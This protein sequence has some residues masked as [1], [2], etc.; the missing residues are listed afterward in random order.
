[1]DHLRAEDSQLPSPAVRRPDAA[2]AQNDILKLQQS[3]GN[4]AVAARAQEEAEGSPGHRPNLALG[5]SGP[6][7]L[8]LQR[9]LRELGLGCPADGTFGQSTHDAVVGYQQHHPELLPATGGVGPGTWATVDRET[10]PLTGPT[11]DLLPPNTTN[12]LGVSTSTDPLTQLEIQVLQGTLDGRVPWYVVLPVRKIL[13]V[14]YTMGTAPLLLAK[15]V[16]DV[17]HFV[18]SGRWEAEKAQGH[19]PLLE[20]LLNSHLSDTLLHT[21]VITDLLGEDIAMAAGLLLSRYPHAGP[22][23]RHYLHGHGADYKYD[24]QDFANTHSGFGLLVSGS[25]PLDGSTKVITDFAADSDGGSSDWAYTFG[26][27][28]HISLRLIDGSDR[29]RAKVRVVLADPYQWHGD[30]LRGELLLH[31]SMEILK[32]TGAQEFMQRDDGNLVTVDLSG[33]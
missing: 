16:Y 31:K 26:H 8:L 11:Q 6:G 20:L 23:F 2:P 3:A 33:R 10:A 28:D 7:V 27:I 17:V 19:S 9:K 12:P 4:A 25:T 32:Q 30:E 13:R 15:F 1:M 29:T 18:E 22:T 5:D 14:L 21:D 24:L